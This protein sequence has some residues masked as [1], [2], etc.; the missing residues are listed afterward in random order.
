M[1]IKRT[2]PVDD[3]NLYFQV[4]LIF[5]CATRRRTLRATLTQTLSVPLPLPLR[6]CLTHYCSEFAEASHVQHNFSERLA[7]ETRY[8]NALTCRGPFLFPPSLPFSVHAHVRVCVRVNVC[9]CAEDV[10]HY[11]R[12]VD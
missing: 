11:E 5:C 6:S 7:D 2:K 4:E 3:F 10:W 9:V 1:L 8:M 12:E